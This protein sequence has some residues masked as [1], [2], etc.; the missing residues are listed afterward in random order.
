MKK[1]LIALILVVFPISAYAG[2]TAIMGAG[3]GHEDRTTLATSTMEYEH[4]EVHNGS[5]FF[6]SDFDTLASGASIEYVLTTPNTT[7]WAH[8][9]VSMTGSAITEI[10]I[11]EGTVRSGVS[12]INIR[13]NNRNSSTAATCALAKY[14]TAGDSGVTIYKMKSGAATNQSRTP[15]VSGRNQELVLK[16]NTKYLFRVLSGSAD[17]LANIQFEWYEHTDK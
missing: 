5:H 11:F 9:T 14:S 12:A 8:L 4:H 16:Q 6:H 15:L 3:G 1:L 2:P 10:Y 7:K 13:N 17:N